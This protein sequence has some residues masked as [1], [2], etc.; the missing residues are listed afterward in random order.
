MLL[1]TLPE[2][3]NYLEKSHPVA[4]DFGLDRIRHVAKNLG[5]L[6][7]KNQIDN[8]SRKNNN[9]YRY[10]FLLQR[11]KVVIVGGTNGKGTC[12][13]ILD[14][15]LR[16]AGYNTGCYTSPHLIRFN[17]RITI[18]GRCAS[19]EDICAAFEEIN[20][21]RDLVGLS[22]FEFS[23]LAALIIMA[24][25][26]LDIIILEVGLGGRLDAV[27]FVDPHLS[28]ITG[29]ALDHEQWLGDNLDFIG[30]EKA[31]IARPNKPL[32]YGD[33]KPVNGVIEVANDMNAKI[34]INGKDFFYD[35]FN[36]I[37]SY[38]LPRAS[39]TCA[40]KAAKI[41]DP[42][43][44]LRL[45]NEGLNKTKIDGRF[46]R[47]KFNGIN[48]ILDVAHNPQ[49]AKMLSERIQDLNLRDKV[50]IITGIMSD[51]DIPGILS[52]FINLTN[53]WNFCNIP[54]NVRAS[55]TTFL[56]KIL[57]KLKKRKGDYSISEYSSVGDALD[58]TVQ[59]NKPGDT[60]VIFGSF[61][62]VGAALTWFNEA[63]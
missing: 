52:P 59:N 58:I 1:K 21:A 57:N 29:I 22:Y 18:N 50:Q 55:S 47:I 35:D 62:I 24:K 37:K 30:K 3:L 60:I 44:N 25:S 48:F 6:V 26:D 8:S 33:T 40:M 2:W 49:A 53:K 51:K 5:F 61:F 20:T 23:T 39:M 14:S 12:V 7:D 38:C 27:N 46:H 4:I 19:D 41:L 56:T 17:E 13:S 36:V 28:I 43:I 45:I 63:H 32:L 9:K 10:A 31:A 15:I 11:T 54:N 16:E 34:L 42:N